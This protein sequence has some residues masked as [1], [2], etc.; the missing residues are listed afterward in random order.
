M[1]IIAYTYDA[2]MHCPDCAEARFGHEGGKLDDLGVPL[3]A[4]DREGNSV[5]PVF[6]TD[7]TEPY[8][9]C[10]TCYKGILA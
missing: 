7:E 8:R 3:D 6:N 5:R 4:Q 2:A 1:L 10:R 9:Y